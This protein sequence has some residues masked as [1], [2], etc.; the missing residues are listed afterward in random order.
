M[1]QQEVELLQSPHLLWH[2]LQ[3]LR[4]AG[5]AQQSE[6]LPVLLHQGAAG[7]AGT[8]QERHHLTDWG[9]ERPSTVQ[10]SVVEAEVLGQVGLVAGHHLERD[11]AMLGGGWYAGNHQDWSNVSKCLLLNLDVEG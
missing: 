11:I 6:L 1:G 2:R 9:G 8:G 10:Q 3:T 4:P 7:E 5:V